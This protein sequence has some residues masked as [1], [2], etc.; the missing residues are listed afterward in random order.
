MK[1]IVVLVALSLVIISCKNEA[2]KETK[3]EVAKEI[4]KEVHGEI[5]KFYLLT[6]VKKCILLIYILEKQLWIRQ[7]FL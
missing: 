7:N 4:K 2:K 1:K 5:H 6:K 3:K